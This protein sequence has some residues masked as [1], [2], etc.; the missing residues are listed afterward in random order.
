MAAVQAV[1]GL[2]VPDDRLDRL[3]PLEQSALFI[4]QPL[5]LAPLSSTVCSVSI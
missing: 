1:I 5:V 2:E 4:G 3:S